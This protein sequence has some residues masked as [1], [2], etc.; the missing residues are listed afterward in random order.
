MNSTQSL[1]EILDDLHFTEVEQ[2][3]FQEATQVA[4]KYMKEG[5]VDIEKKFR[6]I[7]DEVV[8]HEI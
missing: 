2:K 6:E 5:T 3:A 1:K 8:K 7:I 4:K